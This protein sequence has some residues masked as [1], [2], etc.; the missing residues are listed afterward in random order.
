MA[1]KR[2]CFQTKENARARARSVPHSPYRFS[3]APSVFFPRFKCSTGR[4]LPFQK[5]KDPPS[6]FQKKRTFHRQRRT[7]QLE[8]KIKEWIRGNN[9]GVAVSSY[10]NQLILKNPLPAL[11]E[12]ERE[13]LKEREEERETE[14]DQKK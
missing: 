11:R 4:F 2:A 1:A 13:R 12:R 7:K 5:K 10:Q 9:R 14:L 6:F 3:T 8:Q